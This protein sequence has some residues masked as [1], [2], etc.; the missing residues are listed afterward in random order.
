MRAS[1][2]ARVRPYVLLAAALLLPAAAA[3]QTLPV[4]S[5]RLEA[6]ATAYQAIG[7]LRDAYQ[8]EA[9]EARNKKPEAVEALQE[10]LRLDVAAVLEANGFTEESYARLTFLVSTDAAARRALNAV[11]GIEEEEPEEEANAPDA[12]DTADDGAPANPHI[13][14]VLDA[15]AGT[16]GGQGLLAAALAEATVAAEHAKLAA[17]TDDLAAMRTHA[18]HVAHALEPAE[19]GR[20]PGA[21][22]GVARAAAAIATHTELAAQ[23]ESASEHVRSHAV[24]VVT[25]ANATAERA[26]RALALVRR[27]EGAASAADAAPLANELSQLTAQLLSG[28]DAD[29]DGRIGWGQG[30]GGLRQVEQHMELLVGGAAR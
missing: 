20:G 26:A 22:F 8:A 4:D 6:Y 27:I 10:Q 28:V 25:A 5:A 12:A 7:K 17:A 23:H 18:G 2:P 13:D 29:G 3:A 9:A 21:G 16:P 24:H 30:E 14:H 19:D 1:L 11:L 15:F